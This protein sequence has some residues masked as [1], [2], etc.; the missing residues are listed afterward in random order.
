MLVTP[1]LG[2]VR[3]VKPAQWFGVVLL[4]GVF[5][6]GGVFVVLHSQNDRRYK[7]CLTAHG[8][9]VGQPIALNPCHK[10]WP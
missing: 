1:R 7:D 4:V 10:D 3:T 8:F 5:L 6:L 2:T 9:V